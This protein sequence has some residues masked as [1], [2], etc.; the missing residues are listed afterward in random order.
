MSEHFLVLPQPFMD[1][2]SKQGDGKTP[3]TRTEPHP[4]TLD[5]RFSHLQ[6]S[7]CLPGQAHMLL[8]HSDQSASRLY[9]EPLL[10]DVYT[11]VWNHPYL[12][13]YCYNC[14]WHDSHLTFNC[15][16]RK[17][18]QAGCS[19]SD[20]MVCEQHLKH[21]KDQREPRTW[22]YISTTGHGGCLKLQVPGGHHHKAPLLWWQPLSSCG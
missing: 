7:V 13:H 4:V 18:I 22:L 5:S 21:H 16:Q 20:I 19:Q 11:Q 2:V 10:H 14:G 15:N 9:G 17:H 1:L 12:Q 6:P 3:C 8:S